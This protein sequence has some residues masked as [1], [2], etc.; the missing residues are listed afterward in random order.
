M[1]CERFNDSEGG[2]ST[3]SVRVDTLQNGDY[4][5]LRGRPVRIAEIETDGSDETKIVGLDLFTGYKIEEIHQTGNNI[6][7]PKVSKQAYQLMDI[8]DDSF[9]T[10]MG[11]NGELREDLKLPDGEESVKIRILNDQGN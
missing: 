10:L 9:L 4:C 1:D 8:S 6:D 7:A 5:M 11:D 2:S 3:I